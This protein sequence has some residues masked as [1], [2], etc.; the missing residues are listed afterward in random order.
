M[1]VKTLYGEL[2]DKLFDSLRYVKLLVCDVDGVFSDG[3][4]YLGSDGEELKAFNAKDGYGIKA[5]ISTGVKVAII[6][7][8]SSSIVE[9]RMKSLTVDD[10]I[11][12]EENKKRALQSL[13]DKY[14]LNIKQVASLGDDVPDTGMYS[15][16]SI[17]IAVADAHPLVTSEANWVTQCAGGKGA[18]REV[19]DTI[20]QAQRTLRGIQAASV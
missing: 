16:S 12:G 15:L 8:R 20:M 7:G 18:V 3:Q 5:L 9:N 1:A 14:G 13:C 11:Q 4:I 19:C 2:N 10:I 6:T 17:K